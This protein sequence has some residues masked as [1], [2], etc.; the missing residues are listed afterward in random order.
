MAAA[1]SPS[2]YSAS[3]SPWREILP[4]FDWLVRQPEASL[5]GGLREFVALACVAS[6]LASRFVFPST[7]N[8]S[9]FRTPD[10][11]DYLADP[12]P[13]RFVVSPHGPAEV[14]LRYFTAGAKEPAQ[15]WTVSPGEAVALVAAEF[16]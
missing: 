7:I 9:I 8:M 12:M 14:R 3:V 10:A 15:D 1:S 16:G 6:A 4:H 11:V 2:G 13:P 5:F